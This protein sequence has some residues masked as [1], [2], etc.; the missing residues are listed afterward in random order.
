MDITEISAILKESD[1]SL[2]YEQHDEYDTSWK[3]Y[4][5][6]EKSDYQ[7]LSV[8]E[9]MNRMISEEN[10]R[11]RGKANACAELGVWVRIGDVC[12][13][14][15]GK[16]YLKEAGYQHFGL[17]LNIVGGKALVVPMTSNMATYRSAKNIDKKYGKEHLFAIGKIP[18]LTK[19]SVLFLNDAKF[20]NTARIIDVKGY[21]HPR[22]KLFKEIKMALIKCIL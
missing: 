13:I 3:R 8:K 2:I 4:I 12:Y 17:V 9:A 16:A 11:N 19:E 7:C 18:G 20:I 14:D 21:I 1:P 22:S 5:Q 6:E 10:Y 15:F